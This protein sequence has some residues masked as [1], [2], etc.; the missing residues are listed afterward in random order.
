MNFNPKPSTVLHIDL[1]SCFATIEQQAN[2][3]LR[4]KPVAVAA[5]TTPNGCIVAPS[6]EAKRY[7]VKVGM[8]VRDGKFLCP[9]L[10]VLSPDP[11]K[12]RNVHLAMRRIMS[13]YTDD[14][15]PKSIDEFVLNLGE[16]HSLRSGMWEVGDE[17]KQRIKREIG[18]WLTVSIGIAPNRYLA[19]VAAGFHKPDGL[20]EI[21]KDNFLA[22]YSTLSLV[23]LTGIKERNAAR[24]SGMGIYSVL[25]FYNAPLWKLKAAFHSIA[26]YYW[27]ERLRG[28]EIDDVEFA[29]RS[30]G[31]SVA[32]G[33]TY[34]TPAEISPI[35]A[36][37]V[38]K[39]SAR[40]RRAGYKAQGIH[41]AISYK[42]GFF[43]HKGKVTNK[44]LF[45]FRDIFK[46]AVRLLL[47]S[48]H[49]A[50]VRDI[51]VSCFNLKKET[52]L[53]LELFDDIFKKQETMKAV[54]SI[55]NR[56]G[57]FVVRSGRMASGEKV[58]LDRIAFGGVKELEEFTL[59]R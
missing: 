12:Y 59:L 44:I 58:V 11:W 1:N 16:Q 54:D 22:V 15:H 46:E 26:G 20:D 3:H 2:P 29:R 51:A 55:N 18:E 21:N 45:D 36:N 52:G 8:R 49:Q 25:D 9:D 38:E 57:D 13:D 17:I 23:D 32:L 10:I 35:L 4:G 43:W 37:L 24:L 50:P 53:Q 41:L 14:F 19:K 40:V 42:D 31:N 56:W 5:Y 30:Y 28:Y 6:V 47:I 33:K 27:Y 34:Q 7:G 39:M 48:S